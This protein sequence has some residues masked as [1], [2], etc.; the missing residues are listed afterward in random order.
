MIALDIGGTKTSIFFSEKK[1]L[2]KFKKEYSSIIKEIDEKQ[3]F[4]VIPTFFKNSKNDFIEFFS[5][6]K[7]FDKEIISTF[8]GIVKIEKMQNEFKFKLFSAHFPFLIGKYIDVNFAI[9][10][11]YAFAYYHARKFFKDPD[12]REKSILCIQIG[13]GVNAVHMNFYDYKKLIFLRKIFEAGHI[14]LRQGKGK[15]FCGRKGCAELY[16]AGKYLEDI[17]KGNPLIVFKNNAFKKKYY[18]NLSW[19]VSS[20]ILVVSP[21][22]IVF[23]GSVAKSLDIALLHK[24]VEEKFPHFRIHLN[25]EYEKDISRISNLYGLIHLYKKFKKRYKI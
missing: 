4:C 10:D 18:E 24:L 1:N 16:V 8:P 5:M 23:G 22:K 20:L 15:C 7:S 21:D 11:V 25:I 9:N 19:Y 13:T 14:T 17:G 3:K 2:K 6:L 12:N